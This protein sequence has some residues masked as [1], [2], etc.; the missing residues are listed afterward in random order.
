MAAAEDSKAALLWQVKVIVKS[1]RSQP[2]P[3]RPLTLISTP[4][5]ITLR[6]VLADKDVVMPEAPPPLYLQVPRQG[7]LHTALGT[8]EPLIRHVLPPGPHEPWFSYGPL[9]LRW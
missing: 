1:T 8:I 6:V 4:L 5:Q 9:H 7:Y 2:L 3:A